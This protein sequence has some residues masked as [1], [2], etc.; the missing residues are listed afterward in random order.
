MLTEAV[1]APGAVISTRSESLSLPAGAS[2]GT[3]QVP[4]LALTGSALRSRRP[5]ESAKLAIVPNTGSGLCEES[6]AV[7]CT[8]SPTT[9]AWRS[10]A[11]ESDAGDDACSAPAAGG[12]TDAA[13][14]HNATTNQS[15]AG[16]S[17]AL[18]V[19]V[20][21]GPGRRGLSGWASLGYTLATVGDPPSGPHRVFPYLCRLGQKSR[22]WRV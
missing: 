12:A 17:R 9:A 13:S 22:T 10:N 16:L 4:R 15:R 6:V 18:A 2:V 7:R 21:S 3:D 14:R 5:G 20:P 19:P 8:R 1:C 11:R